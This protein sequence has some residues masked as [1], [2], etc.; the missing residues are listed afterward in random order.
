MQRSKAM[1]TD[2]PDTDALARRLAS[3][4]PEKRL[5]LEALLNATKPAA[6]QRISRRTTPDPPP[7]SFAQQ[8][9]W[10]LDQLL[11]GN[12]FYNIPAALRL[13]TRLNVAALRRSLNEIVRRHGDFLP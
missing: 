4:S 6:S 8:R 11:P 13:K 2:T 12:P 1:A 9:L 5:V 3:L 10:F 7:T